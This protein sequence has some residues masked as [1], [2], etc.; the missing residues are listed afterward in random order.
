MKYLISIT[1]AL[2]LLTGC[3]SNKVV[4]VKQSWPDAPDEIM[5]SCNQ[6]KE[7]TDPTT[8]SNLTQTVAT[9]YS[10]YFVCSLKVDTWIEWYKQQKDNYEGKK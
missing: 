6:L 9:N 3:A 7:L 1:T 5:T 10:E 4:S 2:L 8:L